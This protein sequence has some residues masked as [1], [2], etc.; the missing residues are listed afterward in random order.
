MNKVVWSKPFQYN[1]FLLMRH[2][3]GV[4]KT[5]HGNLARV[6]GFAVGFNKFGFY[7]G[8]AFNLIEGG[9][10]PFYFAIRFNTR[11]FDINDDNV[12]W[13]YLKFKFLNLDFDKRFG[14]E[15]RTSYLMRSRA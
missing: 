7:F 14:R 3:L 10:Y 15:S 6:D 9:L 13:G 12:Y 1:E 4:K 2:T 11:K 5:E 8:A